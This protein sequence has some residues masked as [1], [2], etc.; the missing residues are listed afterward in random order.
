MNKKI[1]SVFCVVILMVS[2]FSAC[3]NKGYLLAKDENGIEHAYVTDE[4]GE[5]VL[6][7]NGDIRI[8][9]TD[10]NGKIVEDDNGNK[11]E[12][13][14]KMPETLKTDKKYQTKEFIFNVPSGWKIG[15][16]GF[17]AESEDGLE[18][19]QFDNV[20][21]NSSNYNSLVA[22]QVD[23]AK[24]TVS[25][26]EE[27]GGKAVLNEGS[28]K[29]TSNQADAYYMIFHAEAEV[30]GKNQ[31]L[32]T[33]VFYLQFENRIYKAFYQTS[34]NETIKIEQIVELF[35]NLTLKHV[36]ADKDQSA[37]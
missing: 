1:I 16:S 22:E 5:T 6:N 17:V 36:E 30:D 28:T 20:T 23:L 25:E 13:Y 29:L 7:E 14:V 35:N 19:I 33:C 34:K 26:I 31:V 27:N 21:A 11:K 37:K 18:K 9:E 32:N 8:Y 3:G 10:K 2:V 4:N 15:E 24:K 12:N